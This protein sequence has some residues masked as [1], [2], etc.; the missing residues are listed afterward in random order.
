MHS[1]FRQDQRSSTIVMV[2]GML[3][4]LVISAG[5]VT[6]VQAQ[7][8]PIAFPAPA[9]FA[10]DYCNPYPC[11]DSTVA[12]ATGDFNGDGKLDVLTLGSGS[13]LD[14]MLGNGDGTFQNPITNN[15]AVS[16]DFLEAIAVGDFNGDHLLDV[17][18][19]AQ[20]ANTGNAEVH[21]Y[22]GN[23]TGAFAYS[24]TYSAPASGNT[25][26]GPNSI[27]AED[28]NGDGK[29]D[30]VAMTPY[31]GVFVF[32]G[33]GDGTFQTPLP[34]T[35]V[36]TD[37]IGVCQSIA[38]ADLN[39]DGKPDAAVQSGGTAG[40]GISIL[41]GNGNGTFGTGTFYP[42]AISGVIADG[43]I[44]IGDV[45]GDKKPDVVVASSSV[46]AIV[47][48]NQGSGTFKVSGTVGSVALNPTNNV[49]LADI[50]ND[51]KL[52][53]IVPDGFGNVLTFYGKGNGTFTTGPWY[54]LQ[55][56][57][58]CSNFLVAIGDFNADG[59]P[60]LL[61]SNGSNTTTVSL[62]RGDGTFETSQLYAYGSLTANNIVA[63]DFNGDGF[64]DI[65]QSII[66]DAS[67]IGINL[68][69]SHGVLGATS[70]FTPGSCGNNY[71]EWI[72][73]GDV[74]GDG[75]AD[76]VAA[77]QDA[78]FAGCQNNTIAV[79]E[80][81][82]TG[83][84][85]AAAY[86]PTGSTTQE[87]VIYLVDVNG[88]GKL[89]IVTGNADGSISVLLNKGNGT[90]DPGVLNTGLT[91]VFHYGVYLTFADFN[92][93]GKIDIAATAYVNSPAALYVLPGNGDGTF[94]IPIETAPSFYPY[95]LVAADFNKDGKADLLVTGE[96]PG[97]PVSSLGYAFLAGNGNGMFTEAPTVCMNFSGPQLPMVA[98]LNGDGNLDVVIPYTNENG[99][100]PG[101]AILEG[102]GDGTF[103]T[104]QDFYNGRGANSAAIAD[105]NGDGMPDI[106][107]MNTGNFVPG[108]IS[109]M[110]NSTQPVSVSPLLLNYGSVAVGAS[111]PETIILTNDQST[112][113]AITSF[114]L[115]GTDPGD[116]TE[117]NNCG[118]TRLP[119][120]DCTITV[121]AKPTVF[122][123]QTATLS[124]KD[125]AGTQTVQLVIDNPVPV[126]TSL[127]PNTAIAG[128]AGFTL[129]VTGKDFVSASVVKWAGSARAT[130]F[131]SATELTA[132]IL[133]TDIAKGGT[134]AVTVTSPAPGG[135]TSGASNFVVDNPVPT[136]TSISP[137]SA[138]HGGAAFTLTATGTN[139]VVGSVIEW[140]GVKLATTHV[141][142]T[143]LTATV[144]STDI[145]TAG[146]AAVTVV[147]LTPG[148]GTSAAKTFTIN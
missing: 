110:F 129:T 120:H 88:D 45:N 62:G 15:V 99:L 89:D 29:I 2:L 55:A 100:P 67:K 63:A 123:A 144:P 52:D 46:T 103:T 104:L 92:G 1:N 82:G 56:C 50:N 32:L 41:L 131:V 28:V 75:K 95:N 139:F 81:L 134:F 66:G 102:K 43:G 109:I 141:S 59:T 9:T 111:K 22:L 83:K 72:A 6:P 147:N 47:Y 54:P 106:A 60:D 8:S 121:T 30:L 142:S 125:G 34:N 61:T 35:T 73:T 96:I 37:S 57:N 114:T 117:T 101:P 146:T 118:T 107:L 38:V 79:L 44:A 133:A 105:F 27:V 98:D 5:V 135:G 31:N 23:G 136:L 85:K 24:N 127:S 7:T 132:T 140:K 11:S 13:Y 90:Y 71:V 16:N 20:N 21:I 126:I 91:S 124:I 65:A 80:G 94:G 145:K 53:I 86:Y 70:L 12:V 74:N 84:F 130:T 19:W 17:A 76:L 4:A 137:S 48:L 87:Q 14:V 58:D 138:T 143:T 97:C 119:G 18:I 33:N 42:V 112:P 148:G 51:K 68:G 36:C 25:N 78:S 122:G 77:L 128:G 113:L 49:V 69:S 115:G 10:A 116:F 108:F 40:G 93:D 3:A 64:P 26:P 39:G